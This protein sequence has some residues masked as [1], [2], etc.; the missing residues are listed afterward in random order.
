MS[1]VPLF[2]I[3]DTLLRGGNVVHS[4][5]F[6]SAIKT[7]FGIEV[8]TASHVWTGMVDDQIVV[9]LLA[10]NNVGRVEVENKIALVNEAMGN[11]F[12]DHHTEYETKLMPG[13]VELLDELKARRVKMGL[14]T[15]NVERIAWRKLG[16]AGL[17]VYFSFGG[18]GDAAFVR[19][20]LVSIAAKNGGVHEKDCV[21]IGDSPLD[22]KCAKEAEVPIIAVGAGKYSVAELA[23]LE[24]DLLVESLNEREKIVDFLFK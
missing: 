1:R 23:H 6:D 5:A 13:V 4:D 9:E 22:I 14:L 19:S 7:V 2:D 12:L 3:D 11:Y 10:M 8:D 17:D 24:P 15:G 16:D 18:F 20:Q 21:L